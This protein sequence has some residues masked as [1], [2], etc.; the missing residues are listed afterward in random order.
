MKHFDPAS[1][2][3]QAVYAYLKTAADRTAA[4]FGRIP[5]LA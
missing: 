1:E 2:Y 3:D 4:R 5:V